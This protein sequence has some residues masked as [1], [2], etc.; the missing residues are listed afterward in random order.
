MKVL[1]A[2]DSFKESLSAAQAAA[3]I[4]K[5]MRNLGPCTCLPLADGGEGSLDAL[6]A[7]GKGSRYWARVQGPRG[8]L[9]R[10]EYGILA[11]G[12]TGV[13]EMAQASGLERLMPGLRNPMLTSSYGTGELIQ[14][15]HKKG[16]RKVILCLGGSATVDGGLGAL[17]ALGLRCV[18]ARGRTIKPGLRGL[19]EL[20]EIYPDK[21]LEME[22]LLAADVTH[23]LDEAVFYAAQKGARDLDLVAKALAN[24]KKH[25]DTLAAGKISELPGS[26]A[27]GAM[28]AGFAACYGAKIQ[29]GFDVVA[30]HLKLE[31]HVRRCDLV[32]TGEGSIDAQTAHGKT[33]AGLAQVAR[34]HKKPVIAIGGRIKQGA[35]KLFD[36]CFSL[37]PG[38]SS[39]DDCLEHA[40]TWL[41]RASEQ[42]ARTLK[43]GKTL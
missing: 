43:L 30:E 11:D 22:V 31:D 20:A 17:M 25:L 38:P 27:A 9:L 18:D 15:L 40:A 8:Q 21:L 29:R 26:G 23:R 42:I 41:T 7:S 6:L 36:A 2:P 13:V 37:V 34:K 35:D 3:A 10:A 5:G 4:A 14:R 32:V 16:I 12:K 39:L 33:P 24:L 1:V 28:A 19:L